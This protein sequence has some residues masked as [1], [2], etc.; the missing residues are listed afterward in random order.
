MYK[1]LSN[2]AYSQDRSVSSVFYLSHQEL[3]ETND[4]NEDNE[5]LPDDVVEDEKTDNVIRSAK[6]SAST[7]S[8]GLE[9]D[10]GIGDSCK[11][12]SRSLDYL[13][14]P[15][16]D[17]EH[18]P[19]S[20]TLP[21]FPSAATDNEQLKKLSL[22]TAFG[23]KKTSL[24]RKISSLIAVP[25]ER[26][27]IGV[28]CAAFFSYMHFFLKFVVELLVF[29][30]LSKRLLI[31]GIVML[32]FYPRLSTNKQLKVKLSK[33]KNEVLGST[34]LDGSPEPETVSMDSAYDMT[35]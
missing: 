12:L 3:F 13:D 18:V 11:E 34:T 24:S 28:F 14:V 2:H 16:T 31:D 19:T 25:T 5:D 8:L 23:S 22:G 4:P 17:K 27:R 32:D 33:L 9:T 26:Y 7:A 21:N 10:S 29:V 15:S 20:K 30:F 1:R 35:G 6:K